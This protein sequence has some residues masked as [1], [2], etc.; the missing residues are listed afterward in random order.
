MPSASGND[1]WNIQSDRDDY[2]D[3]SAAIAKGRRQKAELEVLPNQGPSYLPCSN[4]T[5]TGYMRH[6]RGQSTGTSII[7]RLN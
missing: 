7:W 5:A 6:S 2:R 1:F 4:L 3:R